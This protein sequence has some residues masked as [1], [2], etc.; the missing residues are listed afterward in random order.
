M[1]PKIYL[2][3]ALSLEIRVGRGKKVATAIPTYGYM[4]NAARFRVVANS[5]RGSEMP[6]TE[7]PKLAIIDDRALDR[8]CLAQSLIAHGLGMDVELFSSLDMWRNTAESRHAGIL[9]NIGRNDVCDDLF[10]NDLKRLI[11]EFPELPI[12]ILAENRDLRQ[13]LRAFEA[14][15]RGYISSAIGLNVCVGAI[16]LALAGGKFISVENPDD[17]RQLLVVAEDKERRRTAM[18]TQR[19]ADVIDALTRG[20]PN[21]IIAYELNLRESTVKVHIRNIMKKLHARNRTEII[22]KISDL[23][24]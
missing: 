1:K 9:I 11:S 15:V 8:E 14:G 20:K 19:E 5:M 2:N 7:T 13:I 22:F 23:F 17:L 16:S 21:K 4:P 12:V 18:F 6:D 24:K 10:I 3:P